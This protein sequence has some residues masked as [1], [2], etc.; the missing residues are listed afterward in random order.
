M[1]NREIRRPKTEGRRKPEIRYPTAEA[2]S[3]PCSLASLL[4]LRVS[5]FVVFLLLLTAGVRLHAQPAAPGNRVLQ[6]DGATGYVELPPNIFNNLEEATVEAWVRWD[7]LSGPGWNR[8]LNC[9]GGWQDIGIGTMGD[10]AWFVIVTEAKGLQQIVVPGVLETGVWTHVAAVSGKAGMKLYLNGALAGTNDSSGSFAALGNRQVNRLGKTV[11]DNPNDL[12]FQ[13]VLDEVRVW[14]GERSEQQ[15]REHM[16]R[17]LSGQEAGLIGLWNFDHPADPG[18]DASPGA[19]HGKLVGKA[20]AVPASDALALAPRQPPQPGMA[21]SLKG[22]NG[23]VELPAGLFTDLTEATVEGWV[24]WESYQ[25]M[26]RF[27][28]LEIGQRMVNLRNQESGSQLCLE[29]LLEGVR[30]ARFAAP[31]TTAKQ[32][33]HLATVVRPD[34]VQ[35][36]VNGQLVE[37]SRLTGPFE[38]KELERRNLLGRSNFRKAYP[39]D[40]DFHGWMK[41]VRVW[42]VARTGEQIR[43]AMGSQL[44]GEEPGLLAWWNFSDPNDP[45]RDSSPGGHHAELRGAASVAE[46]RPAASQPIPDSETVT[47]N[48]LRLE[49]N[50]HVELGA[51]LIPSTN[52]YTIECWALA[53]GGLP[54]GFRHIVAQGRQ[55]YLGTDLAGNIRLGD[56]WE[57]TGVPYPFE[58]W[59]HFAFSKRADGASLYIDG[60]LA[61]NRTVPLPPPADDS[62]FRIGRQW[63]SEGMEFWNGLVD[64]VRIWNIARTHEQIRETMLSRL[65][66][67]EPGLLGLWT[68]D[69]VEGGVVKDLSPGAHDGQLLGDAAVIA[70]ERPGAAVAPVVDEPLATLQPLAQRATHLL[71]LD[72]DNGAM[73][74][75]ALSGLAADGDTS[76]TI[77]AWLRPQGAPR[78]RSWLLT[79]GTHRW[80]LAADGQAQ[81]GAAGQATL[82]RLPLPFGEWTHVAATWEAAGGVYTI[83]FNGRMVGKTRREMGGFKLAGTPLTIGRRE[84]A[85]A[86]DANFQ[87]DIAE[88]RLWNRARSREEIRDDLAGK[89]PVSQ[90]GLVGFW[91]FAD[92]NAPAQDAS[93]SH[94]EGRLTRGAQVLPLDTPWPS[95]PPGSE[96][97]LALDGKTGYVELPPNI[98]NG[99]E[100]S[101]VEAW[102]KWDRL[103]GSG[104][105]RLFTYGAAT[106]DLSVATKD[107]KGLWFII[108]DA[109][110]GFREISV[111]G[112]LD[113]GEWVHVAAVSGQAGMKLYANGRLVGSHSYAG[114]FAALKNGELN[115]IG[116]T[117]TPN[118]LD[119][120]LQGQVDEFRVWKVARTEEQIREHQWRK[121]TGKEPGLAA[122]WNFDAA[123]NG[124]VPDLG[125]GAHH[126]KLVGGAQIVRASRPA[127][128]EVPVVLSGRILGVAGEL[129][130]GA[131][132]VVFADGQEWQRCR[133]KPTGE[134][135]LRFPASAKALRVAASLPGFLAAATIP[136]LTPGEQREVNL[137]LAPPPS[138]LG[139]VSDL[140]GQP[141]AAVLVQ[142][143]K[144][145]IR[146]PQPES[147][148]SPLAVV[149]TNQALGIA[150]THADGRYHFRGVAPGQYAVRAQTPAG[151]KWFADGKPVLVKDGVDLAGVDFQLPARPP[152]AAS[153]GPSLST[154][155]VLSLNPSGGFLQLPARSF[156]EL[157]EATVE[158]WVRWSDAFS[159]GP[160]YS[161]GPAGGGLML[162]AAGPTG[163][164]EAS[165][166][167][168]RSQTRLRVPGLLQTNQWCHLALVAGPA[169]LKLYLNGTLVAADRFSGSFSAVERGGGQALGGSGWADALA[170]TL[171]GQLDEVRVWAAARTG[172]QI[173]AQ[174]FERLTGAEPGLAA[175]WNFDD[176]DRPGRDATPHGFDG[177]PRGLA[178][179]PAVALP[180]EEELTKPASLWVNV[181]GPDG[182]GLAEIPVFVT[183]SDGLR[184]TNLTDAVGALR[185]VLPAPGETL[186]LE[187]RREE[188]ACRPTN[189]V[190]QPGEQILGL[191]LRD[192]SSVSGKVLALDG[193]PLPAVVVQAVLLPEDPAAAGSDRQG[194]LAA[195]YQLPGLTNVP[196]LPDSALPSVLRVDALVDFPGTAGTNVAP[197]SGGC[198]IRWMGRLRLAEAG[199]YTF[200]LESDDG[201][202]L[203]LDGQQVVDSPGLHSMQIRSGTQ[204]L[205]AGDH[206]LRLDYF[207]NGLASGCRLFWSTAAR[208]K[209]V[210]PASVLFQPAR[211]PE[212]VAT[213]TSDERGVY[214]FGKLAPGRYQLRAHVSGGFA[215]RDEGR[216]I[217]V[218]PDS[219]LANLDFELA[220]FKQGR[221]QSFSHVDGL[222]EDF[223]LSSFQAADGAMWFGM[224]AGVSRFDGLRF[225][226]LTHADGLPNSPVRAIAETRDGALWFGSS[227][228]LCR[229]QPK[230]SGQRC[231][232]FSTADG[233]P[234]A[235]I[236]ALSA[237]RAGR[238]WVGTPGG[239]CYYDPEAQPAGGAALKLASRWARTS[240]GF[241]NEG[242]QVTQR[243][244]LIGGAVPGRTDD[245][246]LT[247][248]GRTNALALDGKE[249]YAEAPSLALNGDTMTVT[250]WVKSGG[251]QTSTAH[252]LSVRGAG[253]DIFGFHVDTS[254]QELRYTWL[255][256]PETYN[257]RS[258]LTMTPGG[259]CFVALVVTPTEARLHLD[260]GD[261]LK[262]ATN[263][264][265]H[266]AMALSAPLQIGRD[267][268]GDR[269]WTG[270]IA[271]VRFWKRALTQEEI[272]HSMAARP[273]ETEPGL[274]AWWTFDNV[275]EE[276]VEV[277]LFTNAV[278]CLRSD[279]KGG[280]W[281]GTTNGAA[282][283]DGAELTAYTSDHGLAPGVVTAILPAS[284]GTVWLGT[285]RGGVCRFDPAAARKGV[286]PFVHFTLQDG[287]AE[288]SVGSIAQDRS[289]AVWFAAASRGNFYGKGLSRFDGRSFTRFSVAD[290][291]ASEEVWAL[292]V[293]D[294]GDVWAGTSA[295][296]CRYDFDSVTAYARRD[297]LDPGA[298]RAIASTRDG[299]TWFLTDERKLSRH[300]GRGIAKV[301]QAD[302]LPGGEPI[303]LFTDTDGSLLV[304]DLAAPAARFVPGAVPGE[305]PRFAVMDGLAGSIYGVGRTSRG[306]LWYGNSQG[307]FRLGQT[308]AGGRNLGPV[309]LFRADAK[310]G[311]WFAKLAQ[312]DRGLA[313]WDG[314]NVTSF[315]TKDGLPSDDVR[316]IQPLPDGSV[317]VATMRGTA[318]F[319]RGRFVPWPTNQSR[320]NTL[321]CYDVTRDD[322][323]LLWVTTAEGVSFTDG[324]A[325]STL[326]ERDGLAQ[327][328]VNRVHP[329]TNGAVWLG[330]WSKGVVRY[331]RSTRPPRA[332]T[333]TVQTDR[334]YAD[335]TV[336]PSIS[337]GQ[338]VTFK[339]DVVEY[340]T[341]P[342]KRQYRWQ[343]VKGLRPA[344]DFQDGWST[345]DTGTQIERAFEAAG[346]WTLAVQFIDRDLNY[347]PAT[348]VPLKILLPWHANP[349]I[350]LPASAGAVGLLGWALVARMLYA[351]KRREA[352]RLRQ[353]LLEEEHA[354]RQAAERARAEIEAKNLQLE[355][356]RQA[357]DEANR[358]KSQFLANMSHE[359]RTP[360]NA[361]IGYSEMLQEEAEDL[362]QKN[363]IPDLQRIHGAG[364]H[365]LG[366]INDILDLSKVEAGKMTLYLEDF[367]VRRLVD[368]V[369]ATVQPLVTK[370]SNRLEVNCPANLGAMHAD[371]TKVRQ[372]LFNLL[373]NANKFTSE[374]LIRLS[375][376]RADW[377]R[378]TKA[379]APLPDPASRLMFQVQDTGIGMTAEQMTKLFEA[380]QQADASTTRKYGGTGLGL[381][382]SR[383]FCRLMGGDITVQS[384]AGKGSTFTVTLPQRV[385]D[386]AVEPVAAGIPP[387][388]TPH[389]PRLL[390]VLVI[391]DDAPAR[392]LLRRTLTKEGFRVELA[393]DG[394]R[395]L[396]LAKQLQP[397]VITLDVMMPGLD[398]W[399]VLTALKADPATAAIPVIM[400]SMVDDEHLGFALGAADYFTKP[401][402]G[403][404]LA[405]VLKQFHQ[406]A[407]SHTVL[408]VEDDAQTR[409]MLRRTLEREGWQ[410]SEAVNGRVG[411]ERVADGVPDL[412]LLDLMMPELDG[413]GF[414][415]ELRQRPDCRHVPVIVITAK[416]ITPEDRERLNGGVARILGKAAISREQ[417]VAEVRQ[418]LSQR[419]DLSS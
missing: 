99:L 210:I 246:R 352:E 222:A 417:L 356:A 22:G 142:L 313:H 377:Q 78:V 49:G 168:A 125:S 269:H 117:V 12:P 172:E 344:G 6:L 103:G 402:D 55:F 130:D 20:R 234:T 335:P 126:G 86:E 362:G 359:L 159:T 206:D 200:H 308:A 367:D 240:R 273:A 2:A 395:G 419:T 201:S 295:G 33:T 65:S 66:G 216:A 59:H 203:W 118:D 364:R 187:A 232:T 174:M 205:T 353:Q 334:D 100:A 152:L 310:G 50:G 226:S 418:V 67:K 314:T 239:L 92:T 266:G 90:A 381:A 224:G 211:T 115:R 113:L 39:S 131:E 270:S 348:V 135:R 132:V 245:A 212:F 294:A 17:P 368:E 160:F 238:L 407:P 338:R 171:A 290:G 317:L 189:V 111:P 182:R 14:Q 176:P 413:F 371:V 354:A 271:D 254:G 169:G 399:A 382:I 116:K 360:M 30:E 387:R 21:L 35:L 221:W 316:G 372:T 52:D 327:D 282:H 75:E 333:V 400:I 307:A 250:A 209:E 123:T 46:F 340:R 196:A 391:D 104:W 89:G 10:G 242:G 292:H 291:L 412:I 306:E 389:A 133:A 351:R 63:G 98:L 80:L 54:R 258:G 261:G 138:V 112:A 237:D 277:S 235:Q 247:A 193:T 16:S 241:V 260:S 259:W 185:M 194:L 84:L 363:F 257:W 303:T 276:R 373:S 369:A 252:L 57:Q 147:T 44:T 283:Y 186:T 144:S 110:A 180:G 41:D 198:F 23:Y 136:A 393:G 47:E 231:K 378:E 332:P 322:K 26:S 244:E 175:L 215:Y 149:N 48:V 408:L 61:A 114:S 102:V 341:A 379:E 5:V 370:N 188:L 279:T 329:A 243:G 293:D 153:R 97:V 281:I 34:G 170:G 161:F 299:S 137:T 398:G 199:E 227:D 179:L 312:G 124:V 120:P 19:H 337:T 38:T 74:V 350:I 321:R 236:T 225:T 263:I 27:F 96:P 288:D 178:D 87:G 278:T 197:F 233:L 213:T 119:P 415:H 358:T 42:K 289:G 208:P 4:G 228:G 157:D 146:S 349:A 15:I 390:T 256:L 40:A 219:S 411:L 385:Q 401:V 77:E 268:R 284:D 414:M 58:G 347:S 357:A 141:L 207:D 56:Y 285:L 255:D 355:K 85:F 183:R 29:V 336:L 167:G 79:L 339:F 409:D 204:K 272:Q 388:P 165:I 319:D 392:E 181:T 11:S 134:Y 404:R 105:N 108:S 93:P 37:A 32:W 192:L 297:G 129:A 101:T 324:T 166:K 81:M 396:E 249:S 275:S 304:G 173:R 320:L 342:A 62:T 218:A 43:S 384:E 31:M 36:F 325:W 309:G 298:I 265:V 323:G 127:A 121:L 410:V 345:A 107:A 71:R 184:S 286:S 202:R 394:H 220:P 229:Y 162:R 315:T 70:A 403:R 13:G 91:T 25:P 76:H 8:V 264:L 330:M 300:D 301:T 164:L 397:A 190:M 223:V 374:G 163:D 69:Q 343:L 68:F 88:L 83:Y 148:A 156:D 386:P 109:V 7:R 366:L 53:S 82:R 72:G 328:P 376:K 302:G 158:G 139:K 311:L 24:N 251:P 45:G 406:A 214:R 9:G 3:P 253:T 140:E 287:L 122:L 274:L 95:E 191:V 416:D 267:G 154:N 155:R 346:P 230:A 280:L 305:R 405:E 326:D 64:D 217:T 150:L 51:D 361:I 383:K 1:S 151:W 262:S 28:D 177:L 331:Q 195:V 106:H 128:S 60:E 94:S 375:V 18:H 73:M 248:A 296:V 380:F 143:F 365:L 318:R 145:E